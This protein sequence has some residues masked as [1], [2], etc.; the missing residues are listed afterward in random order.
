MDIEANNKQQNSHTRK[1]NTFWGQFK[2]NGTDTELV[3]WNDT[4]LGKFS[5]IP[6]LQLDTNNKWCIIITAQMQ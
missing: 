1:Y 5:Y 3:R 4:L 6:L 2:H